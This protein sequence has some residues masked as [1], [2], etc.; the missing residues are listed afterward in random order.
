MKTISKALRSWYGQYTPYGKFWLTVGIV[1][2][3]VDASLSFMYGYSQTTLHGVGF[4]VLAFLFAQAPDASIHEIEKGNLITG[5]V[6]LFCCLPIGIM[7]Y[8]SHLGYGSGVRVGDI[9]SAGVQQSVYVDTRKGVEDAEAALRM[10]T[11]R[12]TKLQADAPWAA[13][14]KADG[15]RTELADLRARIEEE[16]KGNRGRKAGCGKECER[17]QNEASALDQKIATAEQAADITRQ[18]EATQ[19]KLDEARALAGKTKPLNS[20]VVH[21]TDVA[22]QVFLAFTGTPLDKAI[23][24][25]ETTRKFTNIVITAGGSLAFMLAAPLAFIFAGRNRRKTADEPFPSTFQEPAASVP[26]QAPTI[27]TIERIRE[28]ARPAISWRELSKALNA[29]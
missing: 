26:M 19:K 21:Q 13:T 2:L 27:H 3:T 25:D 1:A 17:L 29:A 20:T 6:G 9:Q 28:Q 7:A 15:M 16:K 24:P 14:V 11:D 5:A 4:A 18:L 22:A 23:H 8:Y 12:M 10:W